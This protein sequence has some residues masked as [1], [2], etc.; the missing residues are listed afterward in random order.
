MKAAVPSHEE[1]QKK[2]ANRRGAGARI[3][4]HSVPVG[5]DEAQRGVWGGWRVWGSGA[6][7]EWRG[8]G[9]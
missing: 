5:P 8:R 3:A 1:A 9:L 4:F 6:D 2:D 7:P